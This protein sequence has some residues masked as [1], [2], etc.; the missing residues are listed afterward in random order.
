MT[1]IDWF[2]A[3]VCNAFVIGGAVFTVVLFRYYASVVPHGR[4]NH[5]VRG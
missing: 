4:R 5:S 3:I 1:P 2:W